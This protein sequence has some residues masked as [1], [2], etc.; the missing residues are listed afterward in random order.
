MTDADGY[1]SQ[2]KGGLLMYVPAFC[3]LIGTL[4]LITV[5][6]AALPLTVPQFMGYDIYNVVSGSME[7]AIPIGSIIYVKKIDPADLNTGDVIVFNSGDSVVM[8]RVKENDILGGNITTK[9]DAN[10]GEDLSKVEYEDVVGIVTRHIPTL[11]QLLILFGST[12]GRICMI[13]FAA[14]GAMLNVLGARFSEYLKY[15][16]EAEQRREEQ[17]A[18]ARQAEQERQNSQPDPG[19]QPESANAV[20]QE[21]FGDGKDTDADKTD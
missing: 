4:M 11:G 12:L 21:Q 18:K 8:H 15:E 3:T 9:G 16:K 7:P 13:C 14:C 5:I 6:A 17:L 20:P 2:K 1:P 19:E 10:D